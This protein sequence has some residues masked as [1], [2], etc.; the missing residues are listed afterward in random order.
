MGTKQKKTDFY[1]LENSESRKLGNKI[2]KT[3]D[4]I[5]KIKNSKD[6]KTKFNYYRS[7]G[8]IVDC[9][10]NYKDLNEFG[11]DMKKELISLNKAKEEQKKLSFKN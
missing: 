6:E 8:E 5:K 4:E 2:N 1:N 3:I 9:F 11:K 10:E 7:D